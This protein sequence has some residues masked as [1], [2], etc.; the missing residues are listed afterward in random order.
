MNALKRKAKAGF[1]LVELLVVMLILV[2]LSVSLLP[3]FKEA[4]CRAQY[5][6][7]A[8]P[9]VAT[10]RTK[11]GLYQY[12]HSKLP[13]NPLQN[14]SSTEYNW[15]EGI[16]ATW[17]FAEGDY[18]QFVPAFYTFDGDHAKPDYD[19]DKITDLKKS[20][21][22]ATPDDLKDFDASTWKSLHF[23]MTSVLDIDFQDLRGRHSRPVDYVYYKIPCEKETDSA[24]LIGC[25]GSGHGGLAAGTGYAVCEINLVSK[26]KKYIGVFERY[27]AK[28]QSDNNECP[29]L[30][31]SDDQSKIEGDAVFCPRHI[32]MAVEMVDDSTPDHRPQIIGT[33]EGKGWKFS[34]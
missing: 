6:A 27:K 19:G 13:S 5:S 7:D 20:K 31:L 28:K 14:A 17:E 33:M 18:E 16:V 32:T 1:T 26:G 29:F 9:V 15:D 8:I 23:G 12:E 10:L 3:M 11:I 30:Y 4:I 25:F 24:Y 2:I 21:I 34:D 22:Y